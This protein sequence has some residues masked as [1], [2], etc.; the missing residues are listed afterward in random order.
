MVTRFFVF[1]CPPFLRSGI[2]TSSRPH[3]M[4]STPL[5][6]IAYSIIAAV[7]LLFT[8]LFSSPQVFAATTQSQIHTNANLPLAWSCGNPN[9]GHCYGVQLWGGANG[10]DTRISLNSY[11][12][13]GATSN[14]YYNQ[15]FVTT[16]M[17]LVTT[18]ST[19][20]VEAGIISEYWYTNSVRPFYFWADNRPNGG[21]FSFHY[22]A[23]AQSSGNALVRI[24]RNGSSN[25]NVLV[26]DS[27]NSF[28]NTST[29][30]NISIAN[31]EVGTEL[32]NNFQTA[33]EPNIY[34]TNNRWVNGS[35]Q[36]IYQGNDGVGT[37]I[38]YPVRAGWYNGQDP[39]HNSTGGVWY[40]CI[41]GYGC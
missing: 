5:T 21:G 17:W 18:N 11:L 2:R 41:P 26:Q 28:T 20:W 40:S 9:S 10:A 4:L 6:A 13:G 34:Y 38:R 23:T 7:V 25:W 14:D 19:Y 31:I 15:S 22:F 30:N 12:N 27:H 39:L 33:N 16:E 24:T 35:G 8:L 3:T 36:F 29:S 37:I 1:L 32:Y